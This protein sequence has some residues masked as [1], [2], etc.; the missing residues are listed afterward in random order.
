MIRLP[1]ELNVRACDGEHAG[2]SEPLLELGGGRRV[3]RQAQDPLGRRAA[4]EQL[5]D[6]FDQHRGLAAARRRDHLHDA[7]AGQH[8]APLALVEARQLAGVPALGGLEVA[9]VALARLAAQPAQSLDGECML[10]SR[11]DEPR[12]VELLG[13]GLA[14]DEQRHARPQQRHEQA[15]VQIA[16]LGERGQ[17]HA[18]HR[19]RALGPQFAQR[20]GGRRLK[21][22]AL[23]VIGPQPL[24]CAG[25]PRAPTRGHER[26]ERGAARGPAPPPSS[27]TALPVPCPSRSPRVR[28]TLMRSGAWPAGHGDA[29]PALSLRRR[30]DHDMGVKIEI[31]CDGAC[32]ENPGP[33]G[34]AQS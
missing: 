33:G 5:A 3:E 11:L 31:W 30:Y 32:S 8:G 28:R 7:A 15:V 22:R 9:D 23:G 12:G 25:S 26:R 6:A 10:E 13:R 19:D 16:H 18:E 34:G 24:L 27:A 17:P 21:R 20:T 2:G 4:R 29:E 1:I 14:L